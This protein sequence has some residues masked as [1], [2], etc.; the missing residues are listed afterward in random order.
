MADNA[1]ESLHIIPTDPS[2]QAGYDSTEEAMRASL[3]DTRVEGI[4]LRDVVAQVLQDEIIP[5]DKAPN[6]VGMRELRRTLSCAI[7]MSILYEPCTLLCQHTYCK[8]CLPAVENSKCPHCRMDFVIPTEINHGVNTAVSVLFPDDYRKAKAEQDQIEH[9]KTAHQRIEDELRRKLMPKIAAE[10]ARARN[11]HR[12]EAEE[13]I[14]DLA[15]MDGVMAPPALHAGIPYI[16][17]VMS[18]FASQSDAIRGMS[19]LTTYFAT[20]T[21]VWFVFNLFSIAFANDLGRF[22]ILTGILGLLVGFVTTLAFCCWVYIFDVA[23]KALNPFPTCMGGAVIANPYRN[24]VVQR[25]MNHVMPPGFGRIGRIGQPH[26][27]RRRE[28]Y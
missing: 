14:E 20:I 24:L 5:G 19:K 1:I 10:A 22:S 28:I 25:G 21:S 13:R 7:C 23:V 6:D 11:E 9:A 26:V 12:D 27:M 4:N 8:G 3:A 16:D 17:M 18:V 15:G 2:E